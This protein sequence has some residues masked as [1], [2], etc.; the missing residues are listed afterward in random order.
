MSRGSDVSNVSRRQFL[1][2]AGTVGAASSVALGEASSFAPAPPPA[3]VRHPVTI[4]VTTTNRIS[5]VDGSG[6]NVYRLTVKAGDGVTWK[7]KTTGTKHHVT[8][9]FLK[10]TPLIDANNKPVYAV[11][12]SE[13]DEAGSGIGGMIDP[14][15]S[16]AY[17][18]YV[19]VF[20]NDTG[21]TYTDDP[22]II[23]GGGGTRDT[24]TE[25]IEAAGELKQAA[26]SSPPAQR[27]KIESIENR[28][29]ELIDQLK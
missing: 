8:I 15:A 25:L 5:Y 3:P 23:V 20:D 10:D 16:G 27:E 29:E 13:G 12:G 6:H 21:L 7:A 9:L 4:D 2:V 19:A 28:L 11:H 18:Y 14:G 22:K 26:L 17:E 24:R 1:A